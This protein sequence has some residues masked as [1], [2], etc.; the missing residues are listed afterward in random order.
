MKISVEQL[1]G[2]LNVIS[3][4]SSLQLNFQLLA[5]NFLYGFLLAIPTGLVVMK[6]KN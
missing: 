2:S 6:Y 5:Q 1:I 3:S 4:L